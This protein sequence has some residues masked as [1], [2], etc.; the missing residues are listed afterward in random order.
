MYYKNKIL[1][2]KKEYLLSK[3]NNIKYGEYKFSLAKFLWNYFVVQKDFYFEHDL[4]LD[5][6]YLLVECLIPYL[7]NLEKYFMDCVFICS[8]LFNKKTQTRSFSP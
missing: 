6:Q 5:E 1:N 4:N 2:N 7:D 3:Y 8:N